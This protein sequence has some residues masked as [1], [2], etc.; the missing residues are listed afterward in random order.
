VQAVDNTGNVGDG[1]LT[2][3][4]DR[5]SPPVAWWGLESYP[6]MPSTEALKDRQPTLAGD[7]PLAGPLTWTDKQRLAGGTNATFTRSNALTTAGPVLD[8][9][10]SY[11]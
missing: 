8:T 5:A 11:G 3:E 2:F 7:T 10:K 4:V 1:S 6:G 9:S